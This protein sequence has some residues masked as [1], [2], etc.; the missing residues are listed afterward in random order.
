MPPAGRKRK[1]GREISAGESGAGCSAPLVDPAR[2][3]REP[4]GAADMLAKMWEDE[5]LKDCCLVVQEEGCE[6]TELWAHRAV[7]VAASRPFRAMLAGSHRERGANRLVLQEVSAAPL[8][9]LLRFV[10]GQEVQ[11]TA[12][13]AL[14]LYRTADLYEVLELATLCC[15][16]LKRSAGVGNCVALLA[17]SDTAHCKPVALHCIDLLK[18]HFGQVAER[19][20][21]V[22]LPGQ[23]L[24]EVLQADDLSAPSEELVLSAVLS[25]LDADPQGRLGMLP[26]LGAEIR[27]PFVPPA[28]LARLEVERSEL[29]DA[30]PGLA[31]LLREAYRFQALQASNATGELR[32]LL[33]PRTTRRRSQLCDFKRLRFHAAIGSKGNASG[34]FNCPEGVALSSDGELVVVADSLNHRVQLF[35][36]D[37]TFLHAFGRKGRSAGEFDMPGGVAVGTVGAAAAAAADGRG[38][39]PDTHIVVT[40]QGNGRVQLFE[41]DGTFVR[42]VSRDGSEPGC[43]KEPTGVAVTRSGLIVVADYQ[44]HRVQLFDIAG[45][46][47]RAFGRRGSGDGE[48]CHPSGLAITRSGEIIVADYQNDRIQFF[49]EDGQFLRCLGSHGAKA[50]SFDRPFDVAVSPVEGHILVTDYENHRVQVFTE[51]GA[52]VHEFGRHGDGEGMFDSPGGIAVSSDGLV[53]VTDCGNGRFQMFDCNP[54]GRVASGR[55]GCSSSKPAEPN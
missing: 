54:D 45:N 25:W 55:A 10:Y 36:R 51:G 33:S 4:H 26:Q 19:A 49:N 32:A 50:G 42:T 22:S 21:F 13:N 7:L 18:R 23:L 31:C 27:W 44:N 40:D 34:D 35:S 24:L 47:V 15:A 12:E 38:R 2:V 3:R 53:C 1:R 16:F 46:L 17:A 30:F 37:G 6:P 11:L 52:F 14:P 28:R 9:E 39:P 5:E 43:L 8:A 41:R 20:S 48:F 29:L